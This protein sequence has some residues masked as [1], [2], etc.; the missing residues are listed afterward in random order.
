MSK[1]VVGVD[2]SAGSTA[3]LEWAI[4]EARVRGASVTALMAWELPFVAIPPE[5]AW[6]ESINWDAARQEA[7][8]LLSETVAAVDTAGVEVTTR[9]VEGPAAHALLEESKDADLLVVGR[10][11]HGGFLSLL[12]G[13]VSMQVAHHA[14]CPVVIVPLPKS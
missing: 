3:A 2:A 5:G 1:I 6:T 10:R 13:S 9:L 8:L 4:G 12:L 11:G 7:E 14:D